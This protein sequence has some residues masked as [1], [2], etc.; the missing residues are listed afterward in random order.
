MKSLNSQPFF[1]AT[2]YCS[3]F[4]SQSNLM[5]KRSLFFLSLLL[6]L[7]TCLSWTDIAQAKIEYRFERKWPQLEQPWYFY[8][9]VDFAY[10]A[11]G[12]VFVVT[13][14]VI[15]VFSA[16]GRYIRT[17]GSNVG[18]IAFN[19][20]KTE[21]YVTTSEGDWAF[22][23]IFDAQGNFLRKWLIATYNGGRFLGCSEMTLDTQNNVY[24]ACGGWFGSDVHN[25]KGELE[26]TPYIRVFKADGTYMFKWG[27]FG[28][29]TGQFGRSLS[30]ATMV[31]PATQIE[32]VYVA[33]NY[34]NRIQVFDTQGNF[35]RVW[36][37][38]GG[39]PGQF[40]ELKTIAVSSENEIYAADYRSIQV[41]TP[42]GELLP[43]RTLGGWLYAPITMA[44]SSEGVV[45]VS[46]YYAAYRIR[47]FKTDG[48]NYREWGSVGS[49]AG[50]FDGT[51]GMAI[52]PIVGTNEIYVADTYNKRIQVFDLEG[53]FIRQW[54]ETGNT[55]SIALHVNNGALEVY[56]AVGNCVRVED[57]TGHILLDT[58][59]NQRVLC[60][61]GIKGQGGIY[62]LVKVAVSPQGEIYIA[63]NGPQVSNPSDPQYL[64]QYNYINVYSRDGQFIRQIGTYGKGDGQ[65]HSVGGMAFSPDGSELYATDAGNWRTQVFATSDGHYLRQWGIDGIGVANPWQG[66]WANE[67]AVDNNNGNVYVSDG[68]NKDDGNIRVYDSVGHLLH[69]FGGTGWGD[70]QFANGSGPL[71]ISDNKIYAANNNRIQ[72]FNVV[73]NP[74]YS[75][76][77]IVAGGDTDDELWTATEL[78][79]TYAY[80]TL[81][82]QG[83]NKNEIRYFSS[84][85]Q[86]D[87]DLNGR[88]DDIAGI[89]SRTNLQLAINSW[90]TQS[91]TD[92][93][94]LYLIDHG[95]DGSFKLGNGENLSVVELDSWLDQLELAVPSLQRITIII[96]ACESG[97]FLSVLAGPKR[98]IITSAAP[99]QNAYFLTQGVVSFSSYFWTHLFHGNDLRAAFDHASKVMSAYQLPQVDFNG[100]G[101]A[102]ED[103]DLAQLNNQF[104]GNGIGARS[105]GPL[106]A[107]VLSTPAVLPVVGGN[108][109]ISAEITDGDGI[110]DAYAIIRS[111]DFDPGATN[112]TITDLPKIPLNY[113]SSTRRYEGG[114]SFTKPG[115][116]VVTLYAEDTNYNAADPRQ[117]T[118]SVDSGKQ[119]RAIILEGYGAGTALTASFKDNAKLAYDALR[120]QGYSA[121][122]IYYLSNSGLPGVDATATASNLE[123]AVTQWG[124]GDTEDLAVYLIA[125]RAQLDN[126]PGFLLSRN[127][128][129]NT[130]ASVT[131]NQFAQ[132]LDMRQTSAGFNQTTGLPYNGIFAAEDQPRI[133]AHTPSG[134]I[135]APEVTLE[136]TPITPRIG[137]RITA[138]W[139]SMAIIKLPFMPST[140]TPSKVSPQ[141]RY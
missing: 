58:H 84:A 128:N 71:A 141:Q 36:G 83:F 105:S 118:I 67:I 74:D 34:N 45:M 100:N 9:A 102:N 133:I 41:F 125:D 16:D 29:A 44:I 51:S 94:I 62:W 27:G 126:Q 89:P 57:A 35:N 23:K 17:F 73:S 76:A 109:T 140:K 104:I 61:T 7:F 106:I 40:D 117:L 10:G 31:N 113:N 127:E 124:M 20:Q 32:E 123:Y 11:G 2:Q 65:F 25:N 103:A 6:L 18:S 52:N 39:K 98:S 77:I 131:L 38:K 110:L 46:E 93:L 63:T 55:G 101:I 14:G 24:I 26:G 50:Q 116:Y 60:G 91:D 21:L 13:N 5:W 134:E 43:N 72:I 48:S 47:L 42:Q 75:K 82:S 53:K 112:N 56:V 64:S 97:S 86:Q 137:V 4:T 138:N 8:R 139:M 95:G 30:L 107:N 114:G 81:T 19:R 54:Q 96:D 80:R 90:T 49:N 129:E 66:W 59:G 132:W 87:L 85:T 3:P 115:T 122:N 15:R 119:R 120:R 70:G 135:Q 28:T 108:A 92:N 68:W 136:K 88:M 69:K 99:L 78:N 37:S 79:A 33:D 12:E 130:F 111:P 1:G 121:D 22:V